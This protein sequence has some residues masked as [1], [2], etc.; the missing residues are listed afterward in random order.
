[1][2]GLGEGGGG[3]TP[4]SNIVRIVNTFDIYGPPL[5]V[6]NSGPVKT[7]SIEGVTTH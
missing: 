7:L 2:L 6:Q 1:M 4:N 5:S 3:V